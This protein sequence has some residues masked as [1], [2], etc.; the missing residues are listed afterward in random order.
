MTFGCN[1]SLFPPFGINLECGSFISTAFYGERELQIKCYV[2]W[3]GKG[4]L[5]IQKHMPCMKNVSH[6]IPGISS[7][8]DWVLSPPPTLNILFFKRLSVPLLDFNFS[9][10]TKVWLKLIKDKLCD[11]FLLEL[12][13]YLKLR[14]VHSHAWSMGTAPPLQILLVICC[15]Y[16]LMQISIKCME[17][18]IRRYRHQ[19]HNFFYRRVQCKEK[20]VTKT[21]E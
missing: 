21:L 9:R 4:L 19:S 5:L 12:I 11:N 3:G 2:L 20:E 17:P 1:K 8:Q 6:S 14:P 13:V 7:W 16:S 10:M 18:A 15:H